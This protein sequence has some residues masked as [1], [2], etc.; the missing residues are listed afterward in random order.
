MIVHIREPHYGE[1]TPCLSLVYELWGLDAR[2]RCRAQWVACWQGGH[3][4]PKFYVAVDDRDKVI[5]FVAFYRSMQL[6]VDIIWLAVSPRVQRQGVGKQLMQHALARIEDM[7]G[8]GNNVVEVI[9]TKRAFYYQ[10]GFF[11]VHH[12]GNDYYLMIR[13]TPGTEYGL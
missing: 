3:Y 11:P 6:T 9:T 8:P 13:L 5:G 4:A 12:L 7:G 1:I 2:E 10:H